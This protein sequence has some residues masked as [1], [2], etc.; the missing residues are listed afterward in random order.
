MGS[1]LAMFAS[2]KVIRTITGSPAHASG[3]KLSQILN[4][5]Q[6]NFIICS[7][8]TRAEQ[9]AEQLNF[10]APILPTAILPAWDTLPFE[11]VSPGREPSGDR[12]AALSQILIEQRGTLIISVAALLQ[13]SLPR[14]ILTELTLKLTS[15]TPANYALIAQHLVAAGY[16]KTSLVQEVGEFALRG[17]VIDF[18]PA[19]QKTPIR[20]EFT[21]DYLHKIR[22]FDPESQRSNETLLDV[23][24]FPIRE[25]LNFKFYAQNHPQDTWQKR[26][27]ARSKELEIPTSYLQNVLE[28]LLGGESIPADELITAVALQEFEPITKFAK[29]ANVYLDQPDSL[30]LLLHSHWEHI[31]ERYQ[32]QKDEKFILPTIEQVYLAPTSF[33][34]ELQ[35]FNITLI[36]PERDEKN[37]AQEIRPEPN[38]ELLSSKLG[39]KLP[40]IQ[41]EALFFKFIEHWRSKNYQICF[42]V[43]NP[44]RASLLK[45]KLLAKDLEATISELAFEK[46]KNL[47]NKSGL[48]I[49]LGQ[50]SN[51]LKIH[52][53]KLII[54]SEVEALGSHS[55]RRGVHKKNNIRKLLGTLN[56]LNPGGLIVHED[57]GIGIYQ[58]L[59][60]LT[61]EGLVN[62]FI[63]LDYADSK[64]FLPIQ[65]VG[66]IQKY[67]ASDDSQ[68]Q[69]DKL[70][71]K[72]WQQTKQ[73]VRQAV[74]ELAGDLIKLYATRS[75]AKG[76]SYGKTG[77]DDLAFAEDFS[78]DETADQLKAI[79]ET[80]HDMQQQKPMDRLICGDVGFGKT[81]VAMRAAFKAAI[82]GKQVA[83]LAPTTVLVEQH[84]ESFEKRFA[85]FPVRIGAL[86][87]FYSR[88][89]NATTLERMQEGKLDIIIGTHALLQNNIKFHDLGLVII[90]EE[91]RFGVKQKELL[92]RLRTQIDVLSLTAT[93]IPRTLHM[94]LLGIR[95][96]SIISTAPLQRHAVKTYLAINEEHVIK[97][98][99]IRE[100]QRGGQVFFVHNR[101]QSIE[102]MAHQL[103]EMLPD[104][105]IAV[106]HGQMKPAILERIMHSFVK[107]EVDLLVSTTIIESGLDIPNANTMIINRADALGLSQLYQLRGRVGR[108]HRQA[109]AYL[110]IPK[111]KDLSAEAHERLK[112]LQELD[113]LGRGFNLALR[114]LEI[115]GAG[116]LLGQQQSGNVTAIGYD[117]YVKILHEAVFNLRGHELSL[118][119][120]IEP[121]V[122]VPVS[123]FIPE[124]YIPDVSERLL[125]Y[126]RLSSM[127][128]PEEAQEYNLEIED[129]YGAIPEE[130]ANLIALMSFRC[131]LKHFGVLRLEI[132]ETAIRIGFDSAAP[133]N[134]QNL[135]KLVQSQPKKFKLHENNFT[136]II[137]PSQSKMLEAVFLLIL[138]ILRRVTNKSID[139]TPCS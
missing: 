87:R 35:N 107:H 138:D 77:S 101:V 114:D 48:T 24:I 15:N 133:L 126:Q 68:P 80:L 83:I 130:T 62:E 50:I 84:R 79:E 118:D 6:V 56:N 12:L 26:L 71:S 69:L 89:S 22:K 110:L 94:S 11:L 18:M 9:L 41:R 95:D 75:I 7:D 113:D 59:K 5:A 52:S 103:R 44:E 30:E 64:L 125:L 72:K 65:S 37:L 122:K 88:Q 119:Q 31:E 81:E 2:L 60:Q 108:S 10:F 104:L 135:I 91:H 58:G 123:A 120:L 25:A 28:T 53:E 96:I 20:L 86:S 121:E 27:E 100:I 4:P 14:S 57:Y 1:K 66:R 36:S 61:V 102:S 19:G 92:K 112:A 105:R 97:D 13:K 109:Y 137:E 106:A 73:K 63:Q 33:L 85:N 45:N 17:A 99:I 21:G 74:Q 111:L 16:K 49:L 32:R 54:I 40:Y 136:I 124:W 98:A 29:S 51:G 43:N 129:R 67:T 128:S 82:S 38:D 3:W 47:P 34:E 55:R 131:E 90:D 93:P 42:V 132:A 117:L 116:N 70:S 139:T 134:T 115:R 127:Q 39:A 46:F 8:A 23:T 76:F 78:F